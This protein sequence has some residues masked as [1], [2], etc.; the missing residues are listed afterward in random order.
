MK[1]IRPNICALL[2][3]GLIACSSPA[4]NPTSDAS[5]S[6]AGNDASAVDMPIAHDT[7]D[8]AEPARDLALDADVDMPPDLPPM[9]RPYPAPDA[10]TPN[11]GPGGPAVSFTADQL[12]EHCAY[13]SA[14]AEDRDHHNLVAMWNGY[15]VMPW[16]PDA[17]NG[18]LSMYDFSD[19]CNPVEVGRGASV[20]MRET[21]AL[22]FAE[23]D[24]RA[25]T[26]TAHLKTIFEGGVQFWDLTDP[27]APFA[28][29]ALNLDGFAFPFDAYRRVTFGAF[30]QFPY[31][32]VGGAQTGIYVVDATDPTA[33][34]HVSTYGFDPVAQVGQVHVIGNLVVASTAEGS[35]AMLLDSSNP[36]E[37]QPIP[38]GDF[39][40]VDGDGNPRE[41][42]FS[43]V[44]G[45]YMY[46]ARKDGGG[47]LIIYDIRDPSNPTFV[48]DITS[49]GNGGYVF[50]KDNLVFAGEGSIASVY[51]VSDPA[52][53]TL[54]TTLTMQGDLDTI[55]PI[56]NVVVLS[57]DDEPSPD[58]GSAVVPFE[59]EVDTKS[60]EV[61]WSV[62]S[63]GAS[64]LAVTSRVGVTFSEFIDPRSAWEGSVRVYEEG[65]DP[66]L[67][68]V[69]GWVSA[70]DTVVN[71][72][73][74]RPLKSG[75][76][77]V[78]ELPANGVT[79]YN[80][81]ALETPFTLT[82]ETQ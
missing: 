11:A 24:G 19:P 28:A 69:D 1:A 66:A 17:G 20:E 46:F 60:P 58:Q 26:I 68:R 82:F 27:T 59:M 9:P 71:F 70:Q 48:G 32:Y 56:G 41:N 3:L 81:N 2:S 14:G 51:D 29:G 44:S 57:V 18:G 42:Y 45:G 13:M 49:P 55:T 7:G 65:V 38:G 47:G 73:P 33:P 67:G 61:T 50:I 62:P 21:H 39:T 25:W 54:V 4:P 75:T 64:G 5:S 43:N 72:W 30:W 6:D 52:N 10:W 8:M 63:D 78:F 31:A 37:L 34:T 79:D 15:L 35:R 74:K 12:G 36:G 53:I 16:A 77:Y 22:G 40:V 23:V 80:G 76:R